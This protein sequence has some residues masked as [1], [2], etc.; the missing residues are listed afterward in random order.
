MLALILILLGVILSLAGLVAIGPQVRVH[1]IDVDSKGAWFFKAGAGLLI[2]GQITGL[3]MAIDPTVVTVSLLMGGAI[4]F[5]ALATGS[6]ERQQINFELKTSLT[7]QM[8]G[9]GA[10]IVLLSFVLR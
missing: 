2:L 4:L 9:L 3:A 1:Q 7:L 8:F 6:H 5:A 10:A